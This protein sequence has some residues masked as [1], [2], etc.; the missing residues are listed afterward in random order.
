MDWSRERWQALS[1]KERVV[2]D[3]QLARELPQG[4]SF[5]RVQRFQCGEC[6]QDVALFQKDAATFAFIPGGPVALGYDAERPWQPHPEERASWQQTVRDYGYPADIHDY[7]ARVT[8]RVRHVELAP[9]L[10]ET[11]ASELGWESVG[12]EDPVVQEILREYQ[13]SDLH[14]TV[15]RGGMTLRLITTPDG[16]LLAQ[17]PVDVTHAELAQQWAAGGYRFPTADEWEYACG[18][19]SDTLF[20]WGDHAPGNRYPVDGDGEHTQPNAFGL[21]IAANPYYC[22]LLAE[23]G[24]TRGGDGGVLICGGS[25]TSSVG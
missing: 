14:C 25:V 16:D 12:A 23:P 24:V 5:L 22:E 20:R 18:G 11:M 19:G 3:Q 13:G 17:R 10:I 6:H 15:Y 2:C 9:F 1:P 8:L 7:I 21:F 4:F